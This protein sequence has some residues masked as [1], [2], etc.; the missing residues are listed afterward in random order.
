MLH[1]DFDLQTNPEGLDF[2]NSLHLHAPCTISQCFGLSLHPCAI[3]LHTQLRKSFVE[4]KCLD[5]ERFFGVLDPSLSLSS[6]LF[7]LSTLSKS[8]QAAFI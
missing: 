7:L 6:P 1:F 4:T 8:P 3:F 5:T 2:D